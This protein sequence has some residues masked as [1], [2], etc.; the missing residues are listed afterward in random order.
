MT[1][2]TLA[3]CS[4]TLTLLVSQA[5]A[6]P[7][8]LIDGDADNSGWTVS[9]SGAAFSVDSIDVDLVSAI[10]TVTITVTS[11]YQGYNLEDGDIEFPVAKFTFNQ[12]L[13]DANTVSR[14]VIQ[15]EDIY[16]NTGLTWGN[17]EWLLI[18]TG[19]PDFNQTAS[20]GW[21]VSPFAAKT[22]LSGDYLAAAAGAVPSGDGTSPDF[23][24]SDQLVIDVNLAA[25]DNPL[26][27]DLKER[28]TIPTPEP[29]TIIL[30]AAGA[31]LP[32][33]RKSGFRLSRPHHS[34]NQRL[35]R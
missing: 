11:K 16:N 27:F 26:T 31:L 9:L 33:S 28:V 20:A 14:I 8:S 25:S 21:D 5:I 2:K 29:T 13:D 17:Y 15:S 35:R 1:L 30:L 12:V 24:P 23:T 4:V 18:P 3:V 32:L 10:K 7:I 22:F 19:A 34:R 6:A